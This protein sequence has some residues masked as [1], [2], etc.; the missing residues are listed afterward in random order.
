MRIFIQQVVAG[1]IIIGMALIALWP[2]AMPYAGNYGS[3]SESDSTIVT[4][5]HHVVADSAH[6]AF[7]FGGANLETDAY[8][9]AFLYPVGGGVDGLHLIADALLDLDSTGMHT[10]MI[11]VFDG[12]VVIDTSFGGWFHDASNQGISVEVGNLVGFFGACDGCY[13][14]M[15][16]FDGS[17]NKDSMWVIDQSLGNDSVIGRLIWDHSNVADVYDTARFYNTGP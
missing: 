16:P 9:S 13:Q 17:A 5:T 3:S 12:G 8:D 1:A 4:Y 11:T 14:R 10:V 15:F 6:C 7:R 2:V